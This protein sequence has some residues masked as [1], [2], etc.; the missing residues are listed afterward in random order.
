MTL[1]ARGWLCPARRRHSIKRLSSFLSTFVF[2][3]F[4]LG[5]LL[6]MVNQS[7]QVKTIE[8]QLS[9][10]TFQTPSSR[11]IHKTSPSGKESTKV[12]L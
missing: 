12:H 5:A 7:Q 4:L 9:R 8:E 3:G 2:V 1:I 11:V 10:E 6:L